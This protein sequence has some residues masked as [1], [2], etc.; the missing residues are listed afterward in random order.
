MRRPAMVLTLL[1]LLFVAGRPASVGAQVPLPPP[2]EDTVE[3][4]V[5]TVEE[6]VE[7]VEEVVHTAEASVETEEKIVQTA[8]DVPQSTAP[9]VE[10]KTVSAG[11]GGG[12]PSVVKPGGS[13][14]GDHVQVAGGSGRRTDPGAGED[15]SS[16]GSAHGRLEGAAR[17]PRGEAAVPGLPEEFVALVAAPVKVVKTNDA[18]ADASYSDAETTS[19]PGSDVSF[20]MSV[21][22]EG[23]ETVSII[24]TSDFFPGPSGVADREVCRSL[25]GRTL[26]PGESVSC[27]F[28]LNGYAPSWGES[29]VNTVSLH[30]LAGN[31]GDPSML[32]TLFA[33]DASTVR[34][35]GTGVLGLVV[36]GPGRG[37]AGTGAAVWRWGAAAVLLGA[38]GTGFLRLSRARV[39]GWA[40]GPV[41]PAS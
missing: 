22:N 26:A 17:A 28:T 9:A 25:V 16:P 23:T 21:I 14:N 4:V 38:V 37:L 1:A 13:T 6:S 10:E 31:G 12:G 35:G 41:S 18:N 33:T 3:E 34:T 40:R 2:I 30:L 15:V 29:K 5:H 36:E 39:R 27:R 32:R 7:T 19:T 24:R 20:D 11:A 8:E